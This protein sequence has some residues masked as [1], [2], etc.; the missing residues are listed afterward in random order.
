MPRGGRLDA[1]Q[2]TLDA[3]ARATPLLDEVR[4]RAAGV[5]H[6]GFGPFKR[7][8]QDEFAVSLGQAF[9]GAGGGNLFCVFDGHGACGKDA[10]AYARQQLPLLLD[11]EMRAHGARAAGA[12]GVGGGGG[13][14][15]GGGGGGNGGGGNG[16]NGGG[17]GGGGGGAAGD[18]QAQLL[19]GDVEALMAEAF[20][21]TERALQRAGVN[22]AASGTTATV[23][24]QRGNRLWVASAGDSRVVL[25]SRVDAPPAAV[26]GAAGEQPA[27]GGGG[28]GAFG[29]GGGLGGGGGGGNPGGRSAGKA[30]AAASQQQ[31]MAAAAQAVLSAVGA[32]ASEDSGGGGGGGGG[33]GSGNGGGGGNG[34][35]NGGGG[36]A[37]APGSPET[38]GG[39]GSANP[40]A[41]ADGAGVAGPSQRVPGVPGLWRATPLTIDHRPRR[42]SERRRV[43]A[44]GGRVAPKRLPSGRAVGEPRLW[45]ADLPSPGLLLSRSLGDLAAA[46]V[47][48]TSDPEVTHAALRPR[49]D[50]YLVL[51]SDG[52]WDVLGN[53][54][55][56]ELVA[57]AGSPR[58]GCRAVLDAALGEWEERMSADNVTVVVVEF[59]WGDGGGAAEEG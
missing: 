54:R 4:T 29:V 3:D 37:G 30:G 7:E 2:A 44:A 1:L 53:G 38:S 33:N 25:C 28:G 34:S 50:R 59:D 31:Q 56:C 49:R 26:G 35:G 51:A 32:P 6:I 58:A 17:N 42:P 40:T 27:G 22:L 47:G 21:D 36:G 16:G 12:R 8:N 20:R 41:D 57:G 23:V 19:R 55:V 52:V 11:A 13:N 10:A 5:K 46:S 43:E 45:L 39:G 15:G 24:Y 18:E 14:G 48:C 9:G